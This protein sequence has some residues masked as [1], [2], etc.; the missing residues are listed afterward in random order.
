[1]NKKLNK[2]LILNLFLIIIIC[3]LFVIIFLL[4]EQEKQALTIEQVKTRY[5]ADL[6]AIDGVIGVGISRYGEEKEPFIKVYLEKDSPELRKKI[7][8]WLK[9]FK[10]NIEVI[11]SIKG[12]LERAKNDFKALI[13]LRDLVDKKDLS[14]IL[15]KKAIPILEEI[16]RENIKRGNI[17]G[18]AAA[19]ILFSIGTPQAHQLLQKYLFSE[20]YDYDFNLAIRFMFSWG[21]DEKE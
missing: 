9:G 11:G 8:N 7:P 16:L 14:P 18:F 15:S 17:F 3:G 12:L 4:L 21:G 19:Q 6:M 20:E 13:K 2:K 5:E 10:V 1:M